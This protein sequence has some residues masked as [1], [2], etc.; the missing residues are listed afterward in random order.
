MVI[1]TDGTD[2]LLAAELQARIEHASGPYDEAVWRLVAGDPEGGLATI[3]VALPALVA[4]EAPGPFLA[5]LATLGGDAD[6]ARTTAMAALDGSVDRFVAGEREYL[7][8][9]MALIADDEV[10]ARHRSDLEAYVAS[11]DA[12]SSGKPSGVAGIP[13]G[14]ARRDAQ[15]VTKGLEALLGW[16]LRRARSRSDV[17]DSSR[18]MVSLEAIV[19]LIL[20][21][22]RGL[23]VPVAV[24]YRAASVPLLALHV[25]EWD[26]RPLPSGQ[27]LQFVTDLVAGSWL[28]SLGLQLPDAP[29]QNVA[30]QA[31]RPRRPK[32]AAAV[33]TGSE[34]ATAVEGLQRRRERGGSPWQLASWAL[35]VGDATGARDH[36]RAKADEAQRAW[37][38]SLPAGAGGLRWFHK[39]RALAN[40]N[41]VREHFGL[42][43]PLG[44]E[45]ALAA[46]SSQLQ[47]WMETQE[48]RA[49]S[50]YGHASGYLDL[51]VDLISGGRRSQPSRNAVDAVMGP[52]ASV[53]VAAIALFQ[54]DAPG[55]R[56]GLEGILDEHVRQLE[57][58]SSPPP[59]ICAAAV[60]LAGAANR[61]GMAV[62][63]DARF[64]AVP[65]PVD[66]G[67]LPCDVLGRALWT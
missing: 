65:V 53:R 57:R 21:W 47:A 29:T 2:H 9:L 36:L 26:G 6:M 7:R 42:A 41:L 1:D 35:M 27:R 24:A 3:R 64:E 38:A 59:P 10:A 37:Q 15:E 55:L 16:H 49:A 50:V 48:G 40:P 62:E 66:S 43:L 61:L 33:L 18:G 45:A 8:L 67:R 23:S 13:I 25:K 22:R 34:A 12:F 11:R 28:R 17:F 39:D 46:T 51:I 20:A 4:R 19:S 54:R 5:Q 44:D 31:A 30:S 52:Y 60:Q 63:V 32:G 56:S 14:I 58:K